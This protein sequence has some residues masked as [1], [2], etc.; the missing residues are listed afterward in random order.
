M[1]IELNGDTFEFS[2][3]TVADLVTEL[4]LTGRRYA[5]EVNRDIIPRSDHAGHRLAEGDRVE[6]IHAVG[7]G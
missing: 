2:G 5:V 6:V 1:N 4:K 3:E 7:G